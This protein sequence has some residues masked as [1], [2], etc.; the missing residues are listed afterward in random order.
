MSRLTELALSASIG[1]LVGA[2]CG[3]VAGL[4]LAPRGR[5]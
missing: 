1:A 2:C 4:V 3:L 5:W